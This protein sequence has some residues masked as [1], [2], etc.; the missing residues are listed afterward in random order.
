MEGRKLTSSCMSAKLSNFKNGGFDEATTI[1]WMFEIVLFNMHGA[2]TCIRMDVSLYKH[3]EWRITPSNKNIKSCLSTGLKNYAWCEWNIMKYCELSFSSR[4]LRKHIKF[5]GGYV[6]E[7]K[8]KYPEVEMSQQKCTLWATAMSPLQIAL[9]H[10]KS[11]I[12]VT[13]K[14]SSR[15]T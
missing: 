9:F 13:K 12:V 8:K 4:D 15:V 10:W 2:S 11:F 14:W 3:P 1:S 5:F 7:L 6:R